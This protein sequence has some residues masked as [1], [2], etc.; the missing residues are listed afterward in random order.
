MSVAITSSATL[1]DGAETRTRSVFAWFIR[2]ATIGA[3][4]DVGLKALATWFL[5]DGSIVHL[6]E[7][8]SLMLVY[9]T[10][11]AGGVLIGPYTGIVNI[12]V[13]LAAIAMVFR[14][15]TPLGDFDKRSTLALALVTGGALGNLAS[16][17]AGPKGVADFLAISI[18]HGRSIVINGADVLLWTGAAL[19]L[20]V[21]ARLIA[22]VAAESS[23]KA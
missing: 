10:G 13:T 19:L 16:M 5:A 2:I 14:I 8:F 15:V 23:K 22:A 7:R 11:G 20:P 21:V 17:L 4:A 6:T 18:G 1:R 12:V 3:I 9:N